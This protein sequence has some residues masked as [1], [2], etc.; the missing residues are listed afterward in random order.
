MSA[1]VFPAHARVI[2]EDEDLE[3]KAKCTPCTCGEMI[4][5]KGDHNVF[6]GLLD[7]THNRL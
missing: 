7:C 2:F 5:M 6:L 4:L 3:T 1:R